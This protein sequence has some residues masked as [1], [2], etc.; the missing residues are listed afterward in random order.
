MAPWVR[1]ILER[2]ASL[3]E[4]Y[5]VTM[6]IDGHIA[7]VNGYLSICLNCLSLYNEPQPHLN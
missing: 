3:G 7:L 2:L 4:P 5:G 1:L 6:N